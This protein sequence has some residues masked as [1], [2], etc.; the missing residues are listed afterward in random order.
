M[1]S[2]SLKKIYN[3][4]SVQNILSFSHPR[5]K[6]QTHR[7]VNSTQYSREPLEINSNNNA[8][9]ILN[10]YFSFRHFPVISL[11]PKPK[12]NTFIHVFSRFRPLNRYELSRSKNISFSIDKA[13]NQVLVSDAISETNQT[14]SFD[15]VFGP[16]TTQDDIYQATAHKIVNNVLNGY[17]GTIMAYGQ[18]SSGKTYTII[19]EGSNTGII[20]RAIEDIF[21]QIKEEETPGIKVK[22]SFCEIYMERVNDLFDA[23]RTNLSI[24]EDRNHNIIID[25]LTSYEVRSKNEFDVLFRKAYKN[26]TTALTK[27]NDYSSRSHC[28]MIVSIINHTMHLN[29]KLFLVDLAGSEKITKSYLQGLNV[30]EGKMIN[31]SLSQLGLIIKC[32]TDQNC[33]YVPYRDSKLTRI[34]QQ[35]IGG[36]CMT[37]LILTCSLS[38]YNYF[39]TMCTLRFGL[40]AKRIRNKPIVNKEVTKD[41]LRAKVIELEKELQQKNEMIERLKNE[42]KSGSTGIRSLA[43][44]KSMTN[45]V[46]GSQEGAQSQSRGLMSFV[47]SPEKT[48]ASE[49]VN[50]GENFSSD[51]TI[52][53]EIVNQKNMLMKNSKLM[54]NSNN[55]TINYSYTSQNEC[56][57]TIKNKT[58]YYK[59][60]LAFVYFVCFLVF[61]LYIASVIS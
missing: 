3:S 6:S 47:V 35:S 16:D 61:I 26:R 24:K 53:S 49:Y 52:Q 58:S 29:G 38:E 50:S 28:I 25:G 43:E 30:E 59:E 40:R 57:F 9:Q 10:K 37:S 1:S 36:N 12:T 41:E 39:E 27:M 19:G 11:P 21:N 54:N 34:L 32:L 4:A 56:S 55:N 60:Q 8:N 5:N 46:L 48:V 42:I 7:K 45:E 18:T 14:F 15:R 31:K 33:N 22:V 13:T 51:I 23:S 44:D 20:P 17:N 2:R